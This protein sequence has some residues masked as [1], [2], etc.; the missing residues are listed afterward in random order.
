M[1]H[2]SAIGAD[3]DSPSAYA[4]TK[5]AGEEAVLARFPGAVVMRP[6]VIFGPE[7]RFFNL[8]ASLARFAPALPLIG[9]GETKFQPVYVSDVARAVT[10]ALQGRCRPGKIYELG[11]PEVMTLRQVY[12][13]VLRQTGRRRLLVPVPFW[14]AR[15][16]ARLL[17][18]LPKPLLTVDQVRQLEN[19]N[20]V[21]A[22]AVKQKRDLE[23]LGIDPVPAD[24]VIGD[25]LTRFRPR[26][27]FAALVG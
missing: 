5:A 16:Q 23:A 15:L 9:G 17:Q 14:A 12:E 1:V 8:F 6:S 4:R 2:V 20:L 3:P 11:G 7:D 10:A 27:E 22:E 26:G 25:Y 21:S 19:D 24:A 18:L 13:K